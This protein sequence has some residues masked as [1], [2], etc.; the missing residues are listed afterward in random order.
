M[1]SVSVP[2]RTASQT[3]AERIAQLEAYIIDCEESTKHYREE[4]QTYADEAKDLK[5]AFD[6]L[7][8][9]VRMQ[10]STIANLEN[11]LRLEMKE[12]TITKKRVTNLL[13][14]PHFDFLCFLFLGA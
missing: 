7:A 3:D 6:D 14:N 12:S 4:T 11:Q 5:E 1:S 10:E 2:A 13:L 9:K 8:V